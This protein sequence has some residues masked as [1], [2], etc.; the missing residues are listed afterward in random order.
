MPKGATK[1]RPETRQRVLDAAL[2]VFAEMGYQAASIED[3]CRRA[4]YTRG[5]FYSNFASRDELF[6]ALYDAQTARVLSERTAMAEAVA[7]EELTI[8]RIARIVAHIDEAERK[9]YLVHAEF[10]LYA[11]RNP[12]AA[13]ALAERDAQLRHEFA[14]VLG[15]TLR[16]VGLRTC[17]DADIEQLAKMII[18]V[19]EG[20]VP[21]SMIDPDAYPSDQLQEQVIH[22]ILTGATEPVIP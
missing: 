13:S 14:E 7:P 17:G 21:Y 12:A 10:M 6:L 11:F 1:R 16:S 2:E 9:W 20:T 3:I 5:A 18:A 22:L 8:E 15:A 19:R 4:G